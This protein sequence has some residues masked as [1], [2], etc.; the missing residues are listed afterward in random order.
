M[1]IGLGS[2]QFGLNYGVNNITGIPNLSE[3]KGIL[4]L[5]KKNKVDLIDTAYQY[6]NS[7][8]NL[9]QASVDGF[10]VVSKLPHGVRKK[11]IKKIVFS[12]LERLKIEKLYGL[13]IH[14]Y[15]DFVDDP[16]I[17]E[18]MTE[19]QSNGIVDK[20]GFSFF[21]PNQIDET[22]NLEVNL[23]Q[24]PYNLFDTRFEKYFSNFKR[25]NIEI[26][27]RS[28]FLQGLI[29]IKPEN[30]SGNLIAFK[31][32]LIK[33]NNLCPTT[34]EKIQLAFLKAQ[35]AKYIDYVI[36]GVEKE[37]QLSQNLLNKFDAEQKKIIIPKFKMI[38][39]KLVN[40]STW[41]I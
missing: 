35:Q 40:P 14:N 17:W 8:I 11:E 23:A 39:D 21:D 30:L 16:K 3:L 13:L 18:E 37:I 36:I 12:T 41:K 34:E 31:E 29:F 33:F 19:L 7:E 1:N 28:I 38:N 9:G 22:D 5:A 24:I 27:V 10:K 26:H 4:S 20:V 6:G 15:L 2:A 25:K 32:D